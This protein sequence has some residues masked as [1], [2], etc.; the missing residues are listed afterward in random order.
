M[1][2]RAKSYEEEQEQHLALQRLVRLQKIKR[3]IPLLVL[4]AVLVFAVVVTVWRN[5]LLK[6][7]IAHQQAEIDDYKRLIKELQE[8]PIVVNPVAP[9][10][11]L[12]VLYE[13]LQGIA[14]LATVEYLFT[15]AARYSDSMQIGNWNIPGTEK[16]FTMKWDGV[17]KAG[18]QADQVVID[19]D[20]DQKVITVTLPAAQILSYEVDNETIEILDEKNN[21]FNPISVEDKVELDA[22]TENEM[23]DR[24]VRQGLLEQARENAQDI[25]TGLLTA[26]EP[27]GNDYTIVFQVA[28]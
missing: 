28:E 20:E 24:A 16:S 14:E 2:T 19:V 8:E 25:I 15:D 21:V 13:E 11:E 1:D 5:N 9:K 10:I 22:A 26:Y 7:Q 18:I 23:K 6:D 17:I 27:I 4:A 12:D 3:R